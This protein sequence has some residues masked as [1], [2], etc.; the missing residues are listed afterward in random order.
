MVDGS[1]GRERQRDLV[2]APSPGWVLGGGGERERKS[3]S[4]PGV[5]YCWLWRY[6]D[7]TRRGR[8]E[9]YVGD[10]TTAHVDV[11]ECALPQTC[12]PAPKLG[13]A[14]PLCVYV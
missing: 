1:A 10:H 8:D 13:L 9:S 5:G 6:D 3:G 7:K 14:S 12:N 11:L 4:W 2:V